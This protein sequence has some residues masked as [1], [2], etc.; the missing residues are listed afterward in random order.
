MFCGMVLKNFVKF[1]ERYFFDFFK[2]Y[3]F[4]GVSLIG[5]IMVLEIICRCMDDKLNLLF[6]NRCSL[7]E[8]VYVFCEFYIVIFEYGLIVIIGIIVEKIDI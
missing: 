3:I 1:K 7:N 5:K 6:I 4:V 8:I 2:K